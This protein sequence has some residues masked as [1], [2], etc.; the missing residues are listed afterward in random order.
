LLVV[1]GIIAIIACVALGPITNGIKQAKHN[2]AL[3]QVRQIGQICFAYSTDN[4]SYPAGV[5]TSTGVTI[6]D[7]LINANYVTDPSVFV[8]SSQTGATAGTVSAGVS[9]NM[10]SNNVSYSFTIS[11]TAG[12]GITSNASDLI[13]LVYFNNGPGLGVTTTIQATGSSAI[14]VT[15]GAAAPFGT[16]GAAIFYKG[17]NAV[18]AKAGLT[19]TIGQVANFVSAN[20]TDTTS[21]S[22]AQ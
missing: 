17:N 8:V 2:A 1:I 14:N 6:A 20:C 7:Q 18:Y 4:G 9:A 16:D 19:G 21:Y 13:P 11:S 22:V 15:Y 12:T 10:S 5:T 3:Q